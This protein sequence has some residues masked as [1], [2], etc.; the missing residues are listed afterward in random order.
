M[1]TNKS[2]TI[3]G[4][5]TLLGASTLAEGTPPGEMYGVATRNAGERHRFRGEAACA[6]RRA[7]KAARKAGMRLK[8]FLRVH[9]VPAKEVK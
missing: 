6:R 8:A 3:R 2:P 5:I 4:R 7:K 1:S 9:G